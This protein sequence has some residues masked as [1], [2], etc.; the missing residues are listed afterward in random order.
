MADRDAPIPPD[1]E[2][3]LV[4][5]ALDAGDTETD[6]A[7][8]G[9]LAQD[10][11]LAGELQRHV[12]AA[13]ALGELYATQPPPELRDRVLASTLPRVSVTTPVHDVVN[14]DDAAARPTRA[15][16]IFAFAAAAVLLLGVGVG[17]GVALDS[18]TPAPTATEAADAEAAMHALMQPGSRFVALAPTG[19]ADMQGM[20]LVVAAG[21]DAWLLGDEVPEPA[22]GRTHQLWVVHGDDTPVPAG[23]FDGGAVTAAVPMSVTPGSTV[24][25]TDEPVGGSS[26]PTSPMLVVGTV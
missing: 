19:A 14:S 15:A 3:L 8:A 22:A 26:A 13:A 5:A 10:P 7:L 21:G 4:L 1:V 18:T 16:R 20:G 12:E 11:A 23:T 6:T 9:A 2:E 24:A 17:V 25:V